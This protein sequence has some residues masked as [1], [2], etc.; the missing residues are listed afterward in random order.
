M[1]NINSLENT[2]SSIPADFIKYRPE[3]KF[4]SGEKGI[5]VITPEGYK[6]VNSTWI[7]ILHERLYPILLKGC[8][9]SLLFK[10]TEGKTR[11]A[12]KNYLSILNRSNALI[13]GSHQ[14][15]ESG[16]FSSNRISEINNLITQ[17]VSASRVI[18]SD[19][20]FILKNEAD[21]Q[22]LVVCF[23][24]NLFS[25]LTETLKKYQKK[26]ITVLLLPQDFKLDQSFEK[27]LGWHLKTSKSGTAS[28][29]DITFFCWDNNTFSCRLLLKKSSSANLI[30]K[31]LSDYLDLFS[32]AETVS[33]LPLSILYSKI[34]LLEKPVKTVS[35][36]YRSAINSLLCRT[37]V[38]QTAFN[39]LIAVSNKS[40]NSAALLYRTESLR[41]SENFVSAISRLECKSKLLDFAAPQNLKIKTSDIQINALIFDTEH[42]EIKYLQKILGFRLSSMII[43]KEVFSGILFRFSDEFGEACSLSEEK[44]L[45]DFLLSAV[46]RI[47]YPELNTE[48]IERHSN[49]LNFVSKKKLKTIIKAA[50]KLVP[51]K[52]GKINKV[53]TFWGDFYWGEQIINT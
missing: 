8:S 36:N 19:F 10:Q 16:S 6:S 7:N 12:L 29:H 4:V 18:N 26:S 53:S 51:K 45:H 52:P 30:F 38:R 17:V 35:I 50:E 48:T 15:A 13:D 14:F 23:P 2:R 40:E 20:I 28:H 9:K 1:K 32:V 27:I 22:V 34:A 31:D 24:Q 21:N 44:A 49:I 11:N 25:I 47:F 37:I 41:F 46:G 5:T 42:P 39:N 43:K 3:V 33:Q